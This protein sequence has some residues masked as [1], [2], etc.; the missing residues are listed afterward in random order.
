MFPPRC[1]LFPLLLLAL[2]LM[3]GGCVSTGRLSTTDETTV[4][5]KTYVLLGASS[6]FGRGTALRLAGMKANIV[7]AA[8]RADALETLAA[9]TRRLGANTLVVP[10]D[11]SQPADVQRLRNAA[12]RRF[13]SVDTWINFASIGAIGRFWEIP[14]EDQRRIVE[15]NAGGVMMASHAAIRLFRDQGHGTLIN[16]GSVES[17]I[18][19]AYHAT[20]GSTKAAIRHLGLAVNQELRLAGLG[21]RIRIVTI[22]PWAADTPFFDHAA[23]YSGGT[24]RMAAPDDP[25]TVVDAIVWTS[26]HPRRAEMPIGW[27][28]QAAWFSHHL[29][30]RTTER[31]AGDVIHRYQFETAPPAPPTSGSVH[32]P[33]AAGQGVDGGVRRRMAEEDARRQAVR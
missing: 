18:P 16:L 2:M 22:E 13:G 8:R 28:A 24:P 27:K 15:V 11:I 20:Y 17:E 21:D 25:W 33:I 29:A 10:M 31:L 23:N 3:M 12:V 14:V 26:L 19:L 30:P 7:I 32:R 6:G 4:A 5:G 9:E 1:R